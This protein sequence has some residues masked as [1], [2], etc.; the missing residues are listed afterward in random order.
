MGLAIVMI[1]KRSYSLGEKEFLR[2]PT[3]REFTRSVQLNNWRGY[4]TRQ[5][6]I[7]ANQ[8][9]KMFTKPGRD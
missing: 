7:A 8:N 6:T 9:L 3:Q 5:E 2:K 1:R 4:D